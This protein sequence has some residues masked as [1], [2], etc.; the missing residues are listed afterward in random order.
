MN[1]VIAPAQAHPLFFR[2]SFVRRLP[3]PVPEA[4]SRA[5][6]SIDPTTHAGVDACVPICSHRVTSSANPRRP[7]P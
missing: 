1:R 7:R 5:S 3:A 4:V 2:G 6:G